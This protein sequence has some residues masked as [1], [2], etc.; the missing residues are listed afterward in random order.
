MLNTGLHAAAVGIGGEF[1]NGRIR[2]ANFLRHWNR[3]VGERNLCVLVSAQFVRSDLTRT[4]QA[5]VGNTQWN[6]SRS[7]DQNVTP[8][9]IRA[10]HREWADGDDALAALQFDLRHDCDGVERWFLQTKNPESLVRT[11]R[12]LHLGN[13]PI[14]AA[15]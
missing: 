4:E 12:G 15:W 2:L 6:I 14:L 10:F 11:G 9:P 7:R 3:P 8:L 1:Q 5:A 13:R